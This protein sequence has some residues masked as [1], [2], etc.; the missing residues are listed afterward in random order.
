MVRLKYLHIMFQRSGK[1]GQANTFYYFKSVIYKL[2]VSEIVQVPNFPNYLTEPRISIYNS[3][4]MKV[5]Y[6]EIGR[7]KIGGI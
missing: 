6:F 1:H 4:Y 5:L 7:G 3:S 2:L